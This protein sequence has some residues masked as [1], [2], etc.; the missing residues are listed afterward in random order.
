ME[1]ELKAR[2]DR[3]ELDETLGLLYGAGLEGARAR[4]LR[5]LAGGR[6]GGPR[7]HSGWAR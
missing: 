6:P 3:G 4:R 2:L 1:L 5:P 7:V